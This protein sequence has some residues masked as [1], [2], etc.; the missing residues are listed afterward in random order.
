MKDFLNNYNT[1][2]L[3]LD[4]S[5]YIDKNNQLNLF[6]SLNIMKV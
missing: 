3:G 2:N 6:F 4:I 1:I 5:T